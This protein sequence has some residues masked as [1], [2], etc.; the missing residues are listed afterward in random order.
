MISILVNLKK[1]KDMEEFEKETGKYAIWRDRITEGFKRWQNGEKIYD[2]DKERI[3]VLVSEEVKSRW[4][5]F[6]KHHDYPTVSK[7]IRDSVNFFIDSKEK[8]RSFKS[9]SQISYDLKESLTIIKGY[10][11]ILIENYKD[12]LDWDITLKLI[13]IYD[14]SLILEEKIISDLEKPDIEN[15]TYD[16]LIVEDDFLIISLLT[17]YFTGKGYKCKHFTSGSEVLE[18]MHKSTPKLVLLDITLPDI[19]GYKI[20]KKIKSNKNS[21]NVPVFYITAV[22]YSEVETKMEETGADGYFLK[23]FDFSRFEIL[24]DYLK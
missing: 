15:S 6:V 16:V 14:Q 4:Q 17:E 10:S 18:E 5:N 1:T 13:T 19:D 22:S 2:T 11:Q 8:S 7:L 21:K 12:K 23:P 24:F 3:M 20:C 9:M